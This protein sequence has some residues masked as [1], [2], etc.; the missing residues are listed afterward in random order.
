MSRALALGYGLLAVGLAFLFGGGGTVL[1]IGLTTWGAMIG[2]L[3]GLFCLAVFCPF[4]TA[5]GS[6]TAYVIGL[7]FG[8]WVAT[9]SIY[10]PRPKVVLPTSIANCSAEALADAHITELK[11]KTQWETPE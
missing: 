3:L 10:F 6:V 7:A 4:A 8:F 1:Q 11:Y 5:K 9:G 2:P